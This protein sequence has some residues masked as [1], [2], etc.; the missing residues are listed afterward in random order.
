MQTAATLAVLCNENAVYFTSV[1]RR[2][3]TLQSPLFRPLLFRLRNDLI[4]RLSK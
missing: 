1:P 4:G 2:Y 3:S